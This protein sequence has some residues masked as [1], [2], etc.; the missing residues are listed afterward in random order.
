MRD[1]PAQLSLIVET[2]QAIATADGS[3]A[4]LMAVVAERALALT[5]ANA[6]VFEVPEG[7]DMVYVAAAGA[8]A[9]F[10]GTRLGRRGS[11]SGLCV[12]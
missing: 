9:G 11:L 3:F 4:D 2:Q 5:G 1:E 12:A 7:D 6:A 8:A 10:E